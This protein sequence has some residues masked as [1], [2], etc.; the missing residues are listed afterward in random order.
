MTLEQLARLK[1]RANVEARYRPDYFMRLEVSLG[2]LVSLVAHLQYALVTSYA[3]KP[4]L[5]QTT[6]YQAVAEQITR[7]IDNLRRDGLPNTAS[8]LEASWEANLETLPPGEPP[9]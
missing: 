6:D 5:Q 7:I 2:P 1:Y 8:L 9:A 4:E 3:K